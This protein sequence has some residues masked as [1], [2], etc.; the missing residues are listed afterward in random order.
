MQARIEARHAVLGRRSRGRGRFLPYLLLLPSLLVLL[1]FTFW[2]AVHVTWLSLQKDNLA[3]GGVQQFVGLRNFDTILHDDHFRVVIMNTVIF[4]VGTGLPSIVL[5]LVMALLLNRQ[6]WL[7]PLYRVAF[8][9]PT[10]VPMVGAATAWTFIYTPQYGL[11]DRLAQ[12][13]GGGG[14]NPLGNPS[15]ALPALIV[16]S[17]W[18]MSG[19]LMIFFLAGL[20]SIPGDVQ[21]AARAD[22]ASYWTVLRRITI[23]LLGPTFVFVVIIAIVNTAQMVDQLYVTTQGGPN[24]ATNVILWEI[25]Q[26]T[27]SFQDRGIAAALTVILVGAL[28]ICSAL[29]AVLLDR[30]THY[31]E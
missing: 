2:P 20:Q 30:R 16:L 8:F 19:Y 21:E 17:I 10:L 23:P 18:R 1:T 12:L 27:F 24:N 11:L 13:W 9:Y 22:G 15:Y 29:N 5:G 26:Q 6:R 31:E 25:Y 7:T 3:T 14:L 4:M 28:L